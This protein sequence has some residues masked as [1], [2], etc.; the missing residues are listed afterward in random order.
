MKTD[1]NLENIEIA[2]KTNYT[3]FSQA[4][5]KLFTLHG[6]KIDLEVHIMTKEEIK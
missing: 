4:A 2:A 6:E 5:V 1:D 3:L